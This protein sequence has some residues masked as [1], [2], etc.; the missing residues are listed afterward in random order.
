M[1]LAASRMSQWVPLFFVLPMIDQEFFHQE[2]FIMLRSNF[3]LHRRLIGATIVALSL[4]LFSSAS[5]AQLTEDFDGGGTTPFWLTN[6]GG[7]PA[8][9]MTGG[10][11]GS[12]LRLTHLNGG[13]S[14]SVAFDEN[15]S[16]SGSV[17]NGKQ[18]AF[19]FRMS[20]DQA[21]ADAGGCCGS[22]ADGL[23]AGF[24]VT[25]E[26]GATGAA[27]PAAAGGIWER[28]AFPASI[29]IGLDIFQNIDEVNL[30]LFGAEVA[31]VDVQPL[32]LDLNDGVFHRAI[33]TVLPDPADSAMA[34][35]DV[36]VI[37]DVHG[38]GATISVMS[39][40]SIPVEVAALPG[41]RVIAG[42]RT[43]GA[44]V[45]GDIDNIVARQVPEPTTG[46]LFGLGVVALLRRRRR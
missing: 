7:A 24:F 43:G 8:E 14:N 2:S 3:A 11:T 17:P 31:S 37:Q 21:N 10:P 27:N 15:P 20:D 41:F 44:F 4:G 28:P 16:I 6:T 39:D 34:L 33:M 25:A 22:A 42:G 5:F 9:V 13:I 30:N 45:N 19:D 38:A 1:I 29:A 40:V 26:H 18:L 35:V 23:G 12:F 36:D 46:A 32:G